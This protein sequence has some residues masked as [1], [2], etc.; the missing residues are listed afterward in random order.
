MQYRAPKDDC[1]IL[2]SKL[3]T[4]IH[5]LLVPGGT[6]VI[7]SPKYTIKCLRLAASWDVTRIP[8]ELESRDIMLANSSN[9][10]IV[11]AH[12]CTKQA[13]G[14]HDSNTALPCQME[15]LVCPGCDRSRESMGL[16]GEQWRVHRK[17]CRAVITTTTRGPD[18][19][20][21]KLMTAS[22]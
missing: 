1:K 8:L 16:R 4:T 12:V 9:K 22:T 2:L 10:G 19:D 14:E 21:H 6:Y 11:Y 13:T 7:I 15:W 17:Y 3:F 5:A 20:C 18:D